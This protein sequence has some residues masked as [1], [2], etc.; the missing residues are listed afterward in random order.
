MP[1]TTIPAVMPAT[2][3]MTNMATTIAVT[4]EPFRQLTAPEGTAFGAMWLV[5][6]FCPIV[7]AETMAALPPT[8]R[9]DVYLVTIPGVEERV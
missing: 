2:P 8:C 4:D 7:A 5:E 6:Q 3:K 1:T 9:R